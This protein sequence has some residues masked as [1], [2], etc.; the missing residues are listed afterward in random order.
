MCTHHRYFGYVNYN[1][2]LFKILG[3]GIIN[4]GKIFL[5]LYLPEYWYLP[6]FICEIKL[7]LLF[8]PQ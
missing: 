8:F 1:E 2:F 4:K 7:H 3:G 6:Y 5:Y